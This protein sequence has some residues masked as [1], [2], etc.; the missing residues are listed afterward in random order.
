M[1]IF[2]YLRFHLGEA[3]DGRDFEGDLRAMAELA[4]GQP[5]YRW[6]AMGPSMEESSVYVVVSEWDEIDDVR[7]W[8]HEP[9]HTKI[10]HK[11]EPQLGE[12]LIHRRFTPWQRPTQ[13]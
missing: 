3:A 11:W 5:G 4:E 12:R 13:E 7:R 9:L 2:V 10:Q 1:S 8:E 6:S